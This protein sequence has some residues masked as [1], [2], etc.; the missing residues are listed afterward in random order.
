MNFK[1]IQEFQQFVNG[2]QVSRVGMAVLIKNALTN[3]GID[4]I[5]ALRIAMV[6]S[7]ID[8]ID[9][10]ADDDF[11]KG[12]MDNTVKECIALVEKQADIEGLADCIDEM[13]GKAKDMMKRVQDGEDIISKINLN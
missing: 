3:S 9:D 2:M 10:M 1:S 5:H 8:V 12:E 7:L 6:A 4:N 13:R 11:L